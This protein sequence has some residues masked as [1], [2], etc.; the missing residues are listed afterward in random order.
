MAGTTGAASRT[1]AM[2]GQRLDEEI[3][4][5]VRALEESGPATR[6]GR[7]QAVHGRSSGTE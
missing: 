4:E 6:E 2:A 1:S 7:E 5:L 3:E